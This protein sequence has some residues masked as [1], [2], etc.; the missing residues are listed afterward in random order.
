MCGLRTH[1]DNADRF[2]ERVLRQQNDGYLLAYLEAEN[3]IRAVAG[4]R[5]PIVSIWSSG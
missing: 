5:V 1:F 2:V 3:E 4:Y